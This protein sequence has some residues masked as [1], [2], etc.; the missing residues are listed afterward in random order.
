MPSEVDD[1]ACSNGVDD[2]GNGYTDCKDFN[3]RISPAVT[4]CNTERTQAACHDGVDNDGN[5]KIDCA[6]PT[7]HSSPFVTCP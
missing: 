4:V 7:C 6:D 1:I 5:G 3:C 2:D